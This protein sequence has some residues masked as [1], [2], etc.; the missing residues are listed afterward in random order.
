[1]TARDRFTEKLKCPKCGRQG[2]ADLSQDD[3]CWTFWGSPT[4]ID[5]L[6]DGFKT[7]SDKGSTR[8]F[9]IYCAECDVPA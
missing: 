9:T 1:M 3:G 6:P 4:R 2:V 5:N 8:G 7:V